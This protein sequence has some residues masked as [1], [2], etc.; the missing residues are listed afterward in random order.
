MAK[1]VKTKINEFL[2]RF[3]NLMLVLSLLLIPML[4]AEIFIGVG[5]MTTVYFNIYYVFLWI[6]FS[7]EFFLKFYLAKSKSLYL[8]ENWIDALVVLAPIFRSFKIFTL[9]RTPI[10]IVSDEV[11]K[12]L[13]TKRLVFLYFLVVTLIVILLAADI[14]L[15]FERNDPN[16]N[17]KT[18]EDAVWWGFV[19]FS[20]LGYGDKVPVTFGGRTIA[21]VLM[22]LGFALFSI[23]VAGAV[24]FF[25][26][27]KRATAKNI[28]GLSLDE[29]TTEETLNKILKKLNEIEKKL[30][31]K[32][33]KS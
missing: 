14:V 33:D 10:L 31:K 12:F 21:V 26:K 1:R 17:I 28:K 24:S 23:I 30:D 11:V 4:V 29:Q 27:R 5:E 32:Q 20:T 2:V 15:L 8:K 9:V 6:I 25:I 19:T 18:F 22:I 13:K 7:A 16:S 3:D